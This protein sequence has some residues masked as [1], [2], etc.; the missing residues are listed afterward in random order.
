MTIQQ[1]IYWIFQIFKNIINLL[2]LIY[3]DKQIWA[4]YLL[5]YFTGKL[6]EDGGATMSSIAESS[7]KLL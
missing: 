7:K 6:E 3:E 1:E 5:I 2:V 4:F